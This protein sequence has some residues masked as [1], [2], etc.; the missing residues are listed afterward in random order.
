MLGVI[1][2]A[3]VLMRTRSDNCP[4]RGAS[5]RGARRHTIESRTQFSTFC[6]VSAVSA[7]PVL[8]GRTA[9]QIHPPHRARSGTRHPWPPRHLDVDATAVSRQ[10]QET[11]STRRPHLV[12]AVRSNRVHHAL[13]RT[14]TLLGCD[15]SA[16]PSRRKPP[17]RADSLH[18]FCPRRWF[19][20]VAGLKSGD[21][22]SC[23]ASYDL[24]GGEAPKARQNVSV[25][26]SRQGRGGLG[27]LH[28]LDCTDSSSPERSVATPLETPR[29]TSI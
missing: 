23:G 22:R 14:I 28:E 21:C 4:G 9:A 29:K 7:W 11:T 24:D 13:E 10:A 16:I 20:P 8:M 15:T 5:V 26:K 12:I 17:R 3:A 27:G 2:R 19:A 1:D 6:R 18:S 25:R